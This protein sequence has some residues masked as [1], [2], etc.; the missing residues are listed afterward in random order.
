MAFTSSDFATAVAPG[1]NLSNVPDSAN[2]ASSPTNLIADGLQTSTITISGIS[3]G[4]V[5]VA[6]GTVIGVTTA[7]AFRTDSFPGTLV[8]GTP[9][10]D[11]ARFTLYTVVGGTVTLTYQTPALP[12]GNN[13][14]SYV[15]VV[16]VDAAGAPMN[17]IG[18]RRLRLFG[19]GG[20]Q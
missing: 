4:G 7:P 10:G 9:S 15:Q 13:R 18:V 19:T 2:V 11:D 8:G 3:R 20:G 16:G 12:S 1:T 17:L 14:D 6:D 5:P